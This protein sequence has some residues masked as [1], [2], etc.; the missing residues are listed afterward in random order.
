MQDNQHHQ[1]SITHAHLAYMHRNLEYAA[2]D[3]QAVRVLLVAQMWIRAHH[4][5]EFVGDDAYGGPGASGA[6]GAS[7]AAGKAGADL[8]ATTQRMGMDAVEL[9]EVFQVQRRNVL[10]WMHA[11]PAEWN[12]LLES[13]VERLSV[14][15]SK[16]RQPPSAV[17][18]RE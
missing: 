12:P 2:M 10:G 18:H 1:A 11:H 14:D 17:S 6:S 3:A 15:P 8:G 9:F 7:G 5:L 4:N 13:L 16:V